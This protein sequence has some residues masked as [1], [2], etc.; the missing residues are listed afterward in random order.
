VGSV[1]RKSGCRSATSIATAFTEEEAVEAAHE[2]TP[3]IILSD[4]N[5]SVGAGPGAVQTITSAFGVIPVIFI[6]VIR[7]PARIASL[8]ISF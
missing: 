2:R 5:L 1:G 8:R 7:V 6:T 4:A 3:A